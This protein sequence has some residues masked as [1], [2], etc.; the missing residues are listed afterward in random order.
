MYNMKM[1]YDSSAYIINK[2][3][4]LIRFVI[5]STFHVLLIYFCKQPALCKTV[6]VICYQ[7]FIYFKIWYTPTTTEQLFLRSP[8]PRLRPSLGFQSSR[9]P[10]DISPVARLAVRQVSPP[11]RCNRALS[12]SPISFPRHVSCD[13]HFASYREKSC[14]VPLSHQTGKPPPFLPSVPVSPGSEPVPPRERRRR[15]CAAGGE[16]LRRVRSRTS[17]SGEA[18]GTCSREKRGL[19]R[20]AGPSGAPASGAGALATFDCSDP[21]VFPSLATRSRNSVCMCERR[22]CNMCQRWE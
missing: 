20:R 15:G 10:F 13:S 9:P 16:H 14:R 8:G 17:S 7:F 4:F 1:F 12:L 2:Y 22:R 19:P 21:I 18:I 11:S 3:V 6:F 5:D